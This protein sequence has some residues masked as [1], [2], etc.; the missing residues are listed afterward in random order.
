MKKLDIR[1]SSRTLKATLL[2]VLGVV[3]AASMFALIG[4]SQPAEDKEVSDGQGS[5][6]PTYVI[7]TITS[8]GE[9]E[10]LIEAAEDGNEFLTGPVRVD[11]SQIEGNIIAELAEG[12]TIKVDY[13][14]QVGM[15]SPPYVS[16]T[17]IEVQ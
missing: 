2:C 11:L 8:I 17:A 14:G 5:L 1:A 9:S 12:D 4:C 3:V 7:G 10:L 15:S 16:A 13:S 6:G